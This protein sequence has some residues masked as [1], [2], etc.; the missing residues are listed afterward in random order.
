MKLDDPRKI[1]P[2]KLLKADLV[3]LWEELFQNRCVHNMPYAEHP[4]CWR[5]D[6]KEFRLDEKIGYLDI[7][8]SNLDA[9]FGFVISWCIKEDGGPVTGMRLNEEDFTKER[10]SKLGENVAVDERILAGLSGE[11]AGYDKIVVYWGKNRRHDVPFIRH[12]MMKLGLDFP[13]YGTVY[14][15]DLWD[16][17]KNLL[18]M[19]QYNN[20]LF[21]VCSE[22]GIPSKGTKCPRYYWP[23]ANTGNM[24]AVETIY[25]HNVDDV[26][27]LEPLYHLLEPHYRRM[28][29]S[30]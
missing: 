14:C 11:I 12:R 19:G 4:A 28:K 24:K 21:S 1:N 13:L 29:T 9:P 15:V 17:G 5:K 26:E 3:Y 2:N 30:I 23:K 16:W 22:L 18:K 8:T 6:H 20:S 27:C 10:E 7:E 25:R